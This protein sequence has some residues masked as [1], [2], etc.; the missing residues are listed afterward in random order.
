MKFKKAGRY[1]DNPEKTFTLDQALS[2]RFNHG[3]DVGTGVVEDLERQVEDL[4]VIVFELA[5]VMPDK[6]KIKLMERLGYEL[7]SGD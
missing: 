5:E 4:T 6:I 7:E 2:E 1:V 3:H